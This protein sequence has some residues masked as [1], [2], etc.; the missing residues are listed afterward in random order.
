MTPV[1]FLAGHLSCFL[2]LELFVYQ[3]CKLQLFVLLVNGAFGLLLCW[4]HFARFFSLS[5]DF[6]PE[7]GS[8]SAPRCRGNS[9]FPA[10]VSLISHILGPC[11]VEASGCPFPSPH[12]WQ[13][14]PGCVSLAPDTAGSAGHALGHG[15]CS[16]ECGHGPAPRRVSSGV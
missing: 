3:G 1:R 10:G 2:F 13:C 8:F 9:L 12:S 7:L 14:R 6:D 11:Q 5:L 15:F 4:G 16:A